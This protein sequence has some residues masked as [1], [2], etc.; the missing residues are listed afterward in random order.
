MIVS[1]AKEWDRVYDDER[2]AKDQAGLLL[3]VA[4]PEQIGNS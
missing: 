1:L 4:L 2:C 3:N